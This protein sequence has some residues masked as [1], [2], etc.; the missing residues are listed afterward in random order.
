L[1]EL[2]LQR[3]IVLRCFLSTDVSVLGQ[4]ALVT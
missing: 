2:T 4:L 1:V 3:S